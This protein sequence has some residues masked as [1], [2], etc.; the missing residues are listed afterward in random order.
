MEKEE[1]EEDFYGSYI[2]LMWLSIIIYMPFNMMSFDASSES[3]TEKVNS[4][5]ERYYNML[6]LLC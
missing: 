6:I 2:L 1:F 5:I 4:V 3:T